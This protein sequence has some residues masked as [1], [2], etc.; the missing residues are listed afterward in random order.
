MEY[1]VIIPAFNEE[2]LLPATLVALREAM[3][4]IN[5]PGQIIVVDNNS[6]DATAEI[7]KAHGALVVFEPKNQISRARN[8]GAAAATGSF[9]VFVDA[10]PW[11][12]PGCSSRHCHSLTAGVAAAEDQQSNLTK[13]MK[14]RRKYSSSGRSPPSDL[15]SPPAASCFVSVR[16][17]KQWAGSVNR[18]TRVRK[19]GLAVVSSVGA[20]TA[21]WFSQY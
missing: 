19:Y 14:K 18:F 15:A 6:S 5:R 11:F 2:E 13:P 7:A 20:R 10:D 8:A 3:K 4:E 17:S 16:D 1:S 21:T 9:L 12:L